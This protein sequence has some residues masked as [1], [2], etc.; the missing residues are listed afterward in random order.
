M[1]K[2]KIANYFKTGT[3]LLGVSLLL[4]N[5]EKVIENVDLNYNSRPW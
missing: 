5:C 1:K 2:Q 3:L 4:W